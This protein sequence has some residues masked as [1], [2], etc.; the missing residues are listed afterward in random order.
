MDRRKLAFARDVVALVVVSVVATAV[1]DELSQAVFFDS[2]W[3]GSAPFIRFASN[4]YVLWLA[5]VFA[6]YW[7]PK[8]WRAAHS[9]PAS[10]VPKVTSAAFA[11]QPRRTGDWWNGPG[12]ERCASCVFFRAFRS[13]SEP[14]EGL[15]RKLPPTFAGVTVVLPPSADEFETMEEFREALE[16]WRAVG[17]GGEARYGQPRVLAEAWCGEWRAIY[18]AVGASTSASPGEQPKDRPPRTKARQAAIEYLKN[19]K[20]QLGK[21]PRPDSVRPRSLVAAA[22]DL[23]GEFWSFCR[24]VVWV[25]TLFGALVG[26][27]ALGWKGA[28]VGL[29][30][31]PPFVVLFLAAMLAISS[32]SKFLIEG[33]SRWPRVSAVV[34]RV[35]GVTFFTFVAFMAARHFFRGWDDPSLST[36]LVGVVALSAV[37]LAIMAALGRKPK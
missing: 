32:A 23:S 22:K 19:R 31:A 10:P 15:C 16:D 8:R 14:A 3:P 28:L 1:L 26:W 36:A 33:D 11:P 25:L 6:L 17:E 4:G 2:E 27:N 13:Q 5:A 20:G 29:L 21:S 37:G 34:P 9:A 12:G 30:L 7:L 18:A 35:I 24:P